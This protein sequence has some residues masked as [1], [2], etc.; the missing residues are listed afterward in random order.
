[1]SFRNSAAFEQNDFTHA[2]FIYGASRCLI[3]GVDVL[4]G[5]PY[6]GVPGQLAYR[7]QVYPVF[8]KLSAETM[9]CGLIEFDARFAVLVPYLG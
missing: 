9:P 7:D 5:G 3:R 2:P 6:V 4:L 8:H 1:M